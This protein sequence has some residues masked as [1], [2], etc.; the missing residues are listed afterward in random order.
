MQNCHIVWLLF[1]GKLHTW[2]VSNQ[3]WNSDVHSY[4][5]FRTPLM[6][7]TLQY[8]SFRTY[9]SGEKDLVFKLV[10]LCA[11]CNAI[12]TTATMQLRPITFQLQPKYK[13]EHYMSWVAANAASWTE[14]QSYGKKP[15]TYLSMPP[16][17]VKQIGKAFWYSTGSWAIT[18]VSVL[19]NVPRG[20]FGVAL[21]ASSSPS[22]SSPTSPTPV[23]LSIWYTE[24]MISRP[25]LECKPCLSDH[26]GSFH[27]SDIQLAILNKGRLEFL[28]SLPKYS[29][30]T[31]RALPKAN[32]HV[33][34]PN[35]GLILLF[36]FAKFPAGRWSLINLLKRD[37]SHKKL[38]LDCGSSPVDSDCCCW[39][40]QWPARRYYLSDPTVVYKVSSYIWPPSHKYT[41]LARS[42]LNTCR[43]RMWRTTSACLSW[44]DV[45][46]IVSKTM[47]GK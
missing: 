9:W 1:S 10:L 34:F 16:L 30:T 11:V 33:R 31:P 25:I 22:G 43:T 27:Y 18:R 28:T 29:C 47:I 12:K 2:T 13:F 19:K 5:A 21:W 7:L 46:S 20:S 42:Y 32:F 39:E 24:S 38:P 8:G 41:A 3:V 14:K 15:M 37:C 6:R 45:L 40:W 23:S 17:Y 35:Q 26:L 4:C 44:R 36:R